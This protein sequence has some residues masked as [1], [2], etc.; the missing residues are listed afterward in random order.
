MQEA[1]SRE[2]AGGVHEAVK[3]LLNKESWISGHMDFFKPRYRNI[4]NRILQQLGSQY[5]SDFVNR[6][7]QEAP[8]AVFGKSLNSSSERST[9]VGYLWNLTFLPRSVAQ[10]NRSAL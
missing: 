4:I 1:F 7:R 2:V 9:A 10:E 5:W 8:Q 3:N 6:A